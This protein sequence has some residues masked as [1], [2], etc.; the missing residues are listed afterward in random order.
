CRPSGLKENAPAAGPAGAG[1][2]GSRVTCVTAVDVGPGLAVWSALRR[3]AAASD[4]ALPA[5]AHRCAAGPMTR[6]DLTAASPR[7]ANRA[8]GA[9]PHHRYP[10]R[11]RLCFALG[12]C[13]RLAAAREAAPARWR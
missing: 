1:A 12:A 8:G 13:T 11:G 10:R 3:G 7:P 6:A 2:G 4:K 9:L 5:L